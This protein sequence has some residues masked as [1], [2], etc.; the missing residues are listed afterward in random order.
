MLALVS[1]LFSFLFMT[2]A[3]KL[4]KGYEKTLNEGYSIIVVSKN[5]L[6]INRL[7]NASRGIKSLEEIDPTFVIDS[8]KDNVSF[9]NLSYLKKDLPFFYKVGLY[10]YPSVK[11]RDR[12]TQ[13]LE[14]IN[15]I[16]RIETFSKT[17]N[18]IYGL[19]VLIKAVLVV[20]TFLMLFVSGLLIIRQMEMWFIEHKDR[21]RIMSVFGASL[22][23][24]SANLFIVSI[25]DSVISTLVVS[26]LF[27]LLASSPTLALSFA[28]IGIDSLSFSFPFDILT[29][30]GISIALS[31][32]CVLYV[33]VKADE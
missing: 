29:L 30:F 4:V 3:T 33:I 19:L 8:L 20:V 11:E 12:I 10:R 7:R 26:T 22:W 5:K 28:E 17:Q 16:T 25:I 31:M 1:V 27:F 14:R 2:N 9:K 6:D 18:Q 32:S 24:K 21:M 23:Q 15:S 13:D